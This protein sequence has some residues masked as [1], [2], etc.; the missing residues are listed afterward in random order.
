MQMLGLQG[1][2]KLQPGP[3]CL[4]VLD[5]KKNPLLLEQVKPQAVLLYKIKAPESSSW[6]TANN[7]LEG[8]VAGFTS[9]GVPNPNSNCT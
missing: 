7:F 4:V 6:E 8:S 9:G 3:L 1:Y 5:V 2:D